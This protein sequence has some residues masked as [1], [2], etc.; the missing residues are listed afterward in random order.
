MGTLRPIPRRMLDKSV[1]VAEPLADGA[2][3]NERELAPVRFVRKHEVVA[4]AHRAD[5]ITGTVYVDAV[6]TAGAYEIP[7]GSRVAI[8]GVSMLA[9]AV[10]RYEGAR[11]RV[12][13]WEIDVR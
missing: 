11:G 2:Y 3:G 8:D 5:A 6:M 7:A 1:T 13:H 10:R 12:H 4:D 9:A